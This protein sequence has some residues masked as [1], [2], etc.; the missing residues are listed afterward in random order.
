MR[1]LDLLNGF[2]LH[3]VSEHFVF[4]RISLIIQIMEIVGLNI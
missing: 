3:L 4:H 2:F 1:L